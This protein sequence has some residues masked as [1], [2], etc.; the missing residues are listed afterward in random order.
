LRRNWPRCAGRREVGWRPLDI[1]HRLDA[2]MAEAYG[3]PANLEDAAILERLVALNRELAEEEKCG[4]IRWPLPEYQAPRAK[5][6]AAVREEMAVGT[7]LAA[8]AAVGAWPK[9]LPDQFQ[10][11]AR[12][13]RQSHEAIYVK[14]TA[15]S[16]KGAKCERVEKLLQML[17]ALG[18]ARA[19][20]GKLYG[21]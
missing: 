17:V 2:A 19:L 16:F 13:L 11:V 18:R 21:R 10:A 12:L 3:L 8:S 9:T 14:R 15:R 4:Q 7:D 20:P 5:V 6:V 1:H